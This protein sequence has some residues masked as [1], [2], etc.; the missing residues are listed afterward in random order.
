MIPFIKMRHLAAEVLHSRGPDVYQIPQTKH[1]TLCRVSSPPSHRNAMMEVFA[2]VVRVGFRH[3]HLRLYTTKM[4]LCTLFLPSARV[5]ITTCD[6]FANIKPELPKCTLWTTHVVNIYE[7]QAG[8]A[9]VYFVHY[10]CTEKLRFSGSCNSLFCVL[11]L[12]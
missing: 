1:P 7:F 10:T 4:A 8:A 9:E 6:Q 2:S 12:Q 5:C 11:H 3:Q